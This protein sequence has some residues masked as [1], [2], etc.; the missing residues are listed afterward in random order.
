MR[1]LQDQEEITLEVCV[2]FGL[3]NVN[4]PFPGHNTSKRASMLRRLQ[5]VV[6]HARC[7]RAMSQQRGER[8]D[9]VVEM[10]PRL[11]RF[12]SDPFEFVRLID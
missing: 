2:C 9:G 7:V 4:I 1:P 5:L 3:E 12:I 6:L 8:D 11:S 10:T